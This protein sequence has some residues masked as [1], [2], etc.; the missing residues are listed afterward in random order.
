MKKYYVCDLHFEEGDIITHDVLKLAD[1]NIFRSKR[2]RVI[3]KEGAIPTKFPE[4][5]APK[6]IV[7]SIP[8]PPVKAYDVNFGKESDFEKICG[9]C[10]S[11]PLPSEYWFLNRIP[12]AIAINKWSNDRKHCLLTRLLINAD[13][14]INVRVLLILLEFKKLFCS[15]DSHF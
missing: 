9:Q 15:I 4:E 8:L 13:K 7:K 6:M 1:G 12:N 3:L 5:H 14:T 11:I 2:D 10:D